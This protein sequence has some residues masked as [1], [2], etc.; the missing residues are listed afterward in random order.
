LDILRN[1]TASVVIKHG[2]WPG[3]GGGRADAG[4]LLGIMAGVAR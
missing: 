3:A 1:R 4:A 2:S